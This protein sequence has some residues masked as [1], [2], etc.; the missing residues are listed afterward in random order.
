MC[1]AIGRDTGVSRHHG[2]PIESPLNALEHHSIIEL[3]GLRASP[4][5]GTRF[6]LRNVPISRTANAVSSSLPGSLVSASG[7]R[8]LLPAV[9]TIFQLIL[10]AN[11]IIIIIE[12]SFEPS[13]GN[14]DFFYRAS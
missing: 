12:Y 5:L 11:G 13:Y 8:N 2:S 6:I 4:Q 1:T 3:R 14:K 9:Y 7:G 10:E